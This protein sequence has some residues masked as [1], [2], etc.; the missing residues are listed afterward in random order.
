MSELKKLRLSEP[1]TF[2]KK[3]HEQQFKHNEQVK[4][5][6]SEAKD[7]V[8]SGKHVPCEQS[9]FRSS[10]KNREGEGDYFSGRSKETLLAA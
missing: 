10:W 4:Y 6:V 7:A 5:V 1:W 2:Q 9:L 3:G 8:T